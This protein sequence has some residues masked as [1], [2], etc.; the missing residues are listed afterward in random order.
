[1]YLYT[2]QFF[3]PLLNFTVNSEKLFDMPF[4]DYADFLRAR[5]EFDGMQ[6]VR[7]LYIV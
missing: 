2:T 5:K 6:F 7:T 3:F 4:Q 1:M